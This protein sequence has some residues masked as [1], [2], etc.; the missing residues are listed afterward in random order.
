[1]EKRRILAAILG[2]IQSII[3]AFLAILVASLFFNIFEIR[4]I[5]NVTAELLP[6][7]LIFLSLFSSFSIL[8]GFFLIREAQGII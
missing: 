1:M 5:L 2:A 8:N 7:Y 3:G 6:I 4:A